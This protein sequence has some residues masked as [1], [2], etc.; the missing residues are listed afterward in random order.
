MQCSKDRNFDTNLVIVE[1]FVDQYSMGKFDISLQPLNLQTTGTNFVLFLTTDSEHCKS[2]RFML[3]GATPCMTP[4]GKLS[5]FVP[6]PICGK[7]IICLQN[8]VWKTFDSSYD[9]FRHEI[10]HALGF[11]TINPDKYGNSTKSEAKKWRNNYEVKPEEHEV[12]YMDFAVQ[13]TVIPLSK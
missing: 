10:M 2:D 5:T 4:N 8:P 9:L 3:A 12:H 13:A 7:L 6:R 1:K 11:G